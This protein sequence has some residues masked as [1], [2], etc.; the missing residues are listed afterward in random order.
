MQFDD[1]VLIAAAPKAVYDR[2][3]DLE[4]YS[5]L[6]KQYRASTV[7]SR[8]DREAVVER[9]ARIAGLSFTW[10]S[11]AT[12]TPPESVEFVQV[13]GPLRGMRTLWRISPEPPGTRLNTS[14]PGTVIPRYATK[15][16]GPFF[17]ISG[18]V[19]WN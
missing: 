1:S 7:L 10:R 16:K 9:K 8:G 4:G 11:R 6:A 18:E 3:A 5:A 2:A 15:E 12:F 19:C 17:G 14:N 13:S